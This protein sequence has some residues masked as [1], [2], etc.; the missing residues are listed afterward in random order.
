MSYASAAQA[1]TDDL[2]ATC[3]C[4]GL[5]YEQ[6]LDGGRYERFEYY[7]AMYEHK[8]LDMIIDLL[9]KIWYGQPGPPAPPPPTE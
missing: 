4:K 7:L 2:E 9:E 3:T 8:K 1:L 6:P 5:P